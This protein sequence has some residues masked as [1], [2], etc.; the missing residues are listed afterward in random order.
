MMLIP[1]D[2]RHSTKTRDALIE[3]IKDGLWCFCVFCG[4]REACRRMGSGEYDG[5][6]LVLFVLFFVSTV[7]RKRCSSHAENGRPRRS[8][9][10]TF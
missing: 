9:C 1:V 3:F 8:D 5:P 7:I 4:R 6:T 10:A 2:K